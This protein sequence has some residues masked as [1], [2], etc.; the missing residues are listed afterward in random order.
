[1]ALYCPQGSG[2]LRQQLLMQPKC[3][4][5]VAR[6]QPECSQ[7]KVD[8]IELIEYIVAATAHAT[9]TSMTMTS[10]SVTVQRAT[11]SCQMP[12]VVNIVIINS[13]HCS[14]LLW[15]TNITHFPNKIDKKNQIR[16]I[17]ERLSSQLYVGLGGI[18]L[19]GWLSKVVGS[20]RAPSL[21]MRII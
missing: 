12:I 20:L 5:H 14:V 10:T 15:C 13:Q 7:N 9:T 3:S 11:S 6:I 17:M 8:Q 1:M 16:S 18:G 2:T 21:L 4:H 19:D